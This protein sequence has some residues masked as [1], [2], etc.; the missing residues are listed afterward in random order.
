[1]ARASL[2]A[3][4]LEVRAISKTFIGHDAAP[5]A[6]ETQD[7]VD[8]M[9]DAILVLNAGSSSI[10]FSLFEGHVRPGAKGLI[11]DGE[12]EG[13]GHR[14]HF[15]AKDAAGK[16][17]VDRYLAE[18]T[19]HEDALA[20]LLNWVQHQFTNNRLIAAGHRVV[21]G[22]PALAA[23]VR[24]DS[25]VIDQLRRLIPLA[26]LHQ[27][28]N[29]AAI[30]AIAKLYPG[31]AQ[32]ACFDTAFHHTQSETAAAYALPQSIT[33]QGVRRYGFHGLSYEYIAGVLPEVIGPVAAEG[34]VVVAHLGSGASMCAMHRRQSVATTMGFTALDGLPMGSRCGNLDP[35]V[36]L[37]LIQEKG[38]APQA[39]SDLL[40]HS[41]GL[42]GVSGVS[43]D[44]RTLLASG[45]PLAA[46]AVDLFVYRIGRELG[47]LA[48]GLGGLDAL[49]FTAGI[50]E[51]APEIRRRVCEQAGW[52][53]IDLDGAANTADAARI[54]MAGSR[55]SAWVIPTNEDLMIARHTW[56]LTE[57]NGK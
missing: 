2:R 34:R 10:K 16:S 47:S 38:M 36:V 44:M 56:R 50:G 41:S 43:D 21:H 37:Y 35:G 6:H 39:V 9:S 22:G 20:T 27:S 49:V 30:T 14:A 46:N 11:C 55:T 25:S 24:I 40:Y 5:G 52:L 31:L 12:L 33:A 1:M 7:R 54:T 29:L 51:H 32:V 42:L 28:H 3:L 53:G 8:V 19:T 48:A 18:A 23:P 13:I 26:P 57:E 4:A 15:L 45:D 17:L